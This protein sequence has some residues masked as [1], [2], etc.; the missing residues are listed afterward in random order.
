[1]VHIRRR[2]FLGLLGGA[3]AAWPVVG[4]AQHQMIPVVGFLSTRGSD[5]GAHL[6][7]GFRRGLAEYGYV[8]GQNVTVEYRWAHGQYD[9]L[10]GLA[11]E[12]ARRPVTIFVTAG[13]ERAALA[14]RGATTTVPVVFVVGSDPVR[15]GLVASYN[16]PGGRITGVHIMSETLEA[17]RLGLLH[18][19]I[20]Q[21]TTIGVLVNPDLSTAA[22][23]LSDIEGAAR[24]IGLQVH[25]LRASTDREIEVA[26]E[27]VELNRIRALVVTADPFFNARRDKLVTLSA[28]YSVPTVYQFREYAVAGG[29][30]SYGTSLTDA[31]RQAGIYTA[32]ILKGEKAGDLPVEQPT[33]FEL[34]INLK[35]AKT[36]GLN[37]P[38]SMQLL[39]DDLVE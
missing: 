33:K 2:Q 38:S 5:D 4:R 32:R 16:R 26:F 17:K 35:T 22:N 30:M 21:A 14:A 19:L 36:L 37:V 34:V 28:N 18:E 8:E 23:Q 25:V 13:G 11:A 6:F 10:P 3:A 27:A 31:Y 20:P 7:A 15:L 29:L 24:A 39:A 9:R 12:L 1:M